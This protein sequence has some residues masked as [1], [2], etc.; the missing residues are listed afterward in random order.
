MGKTTTVFA[1]R[2]YVPIDRRTRINNTSHGNKG[3]NSSSF[4]HYPANTSQSRAGKSPLP[5]K[6]NQMQKQ[7]LKQLG[8]SYGVSL[9]QDGNVL[10]ASN[11]THQTKKQLRNSGLKD[12]SSASP[13]KKPIKGKSHTRVEDVYKLNG[14]AADGFLKHFNVP[15]AEVLH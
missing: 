1:N 6:K 12:A 10:T 14:T 7:S 2:S 15:E 3:N 11:K 4:N 5:S 9:N 8:I 13:T